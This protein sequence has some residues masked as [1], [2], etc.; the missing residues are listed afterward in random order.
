MCV[1][2]WWLV[3]VPFLPSY[4][5]FFLSPDLFSASGYNTSAAGARSRTKWRHRHTKVIEDR[6]G[7]KGRGVTHANNGTV[8]C[9][10]CSAEAS[11]SLCLR[12]WDK[13][14]AAQEA[15]R[16]ILESFASVAC[17]VATDGCERRTRPQQTA[18]QNLKLSRLQVCLTA[19]S[20]CAAV[21]TLI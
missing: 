18:L 20:V 14:T 6:G 12:G 10:A 17:E 1:V 4:I 16:W 5:L 21:L 19:C 13:P 11:L 3:S 9:F 15:L 2:W 7:D 8:R